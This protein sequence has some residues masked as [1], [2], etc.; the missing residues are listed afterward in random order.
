MKHEAYAILVLAIIVFLVGA[1][2]GRF[3]LEEKT[4]II[5][6]SD[7]KYKKITMSI[8]AVDN[9]Q[10]GIIATLITEVKPGSGLVL[11][12]INEILADFNT[13]FSARTAAE[14]AQKYTELDLSNIDIIYQIKAQASIIGGPSA[15]SAMAIST[16]AALQNKEINKN[17]MITGTIEQDGSIGQ[18]GAVLEK[19]KVSRSTGANKLLVPVGSKLTSIKSYE[20]VVS[21][22][23][24]DSTEYCQIVYEPNEVGFGQ[25]IGIEIIE[26]KNIGDA[27]KYFIEA[28]N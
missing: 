24:F 9:D 28:E 22:N 14:V 20:R 8:P 16:I 7:S 2:I 12:N 21:C 26:V 10:E 4:G 23:T 6:A 19:A 17:V 15:G 27:V 3:T 1:F 5:E 11:V 18:V 25:E 13:Q